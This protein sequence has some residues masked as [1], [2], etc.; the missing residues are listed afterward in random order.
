MAELSKGK[1]LLLSISYMNLVVF[2]QSKPQA[3]INHSS[4]TPLYLRNKLGM[5]Y[6]K[7]S[8]SLL[9]DWRSSLFIEKW[10]SSISFLTGCQNPPPWVTFVKCVQLHSLPFSFNFGREWNFLWWENWSLK[11]FSGS[12]KVEDTKRHFL[13]LN[14][15]HYVKLK[16]VT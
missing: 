6:A 3:S 10:R 14:F 5:S 7:L 9:T 11:L 8:P 2:S 16:G 13:F 1:S 15:S 4:K 12:W